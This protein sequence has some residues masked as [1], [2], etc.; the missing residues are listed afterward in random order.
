MHGPHRSAACQY[1][2]Y[3]RAARVVCTNAER[4]AFL[5]LPARGKRNTLIAKKTPGQMG[6]KRVGRSEKG[7]SHIMTKHDEG[8]RAFLVGTAI[9]AGAAASVALV[10]DA[11]AKDH[12][13]QHAAADAP[14]PMPAA[15]HAMHAMGGGHGAFF[16]D[17]DIRTITALTERLM[18]GAPGASGA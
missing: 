4:Y 1:C 16:N 13:Q 17:D 8:R 12:P 9:G 10:P 3:R 11:L 15:D 6:P 2:G 5:R 18:P 14:A 7:R